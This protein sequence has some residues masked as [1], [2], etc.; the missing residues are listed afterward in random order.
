MRDEVKGSLSCREQ[1]GPTQPAAGESLVGRRGAIN[2]E[3]KPVRGCSQKTTCECWLNPGRNLGRGT[4]VDSDQRPGYDT[5]GATQKQSW[6]QVAGPLR[7]CRA[8]GGI[9]LWERMGCGCRGG[10]ISSRQ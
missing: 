4:D 3:Q 5:K 10:T 7:V 1:Q 2:A 8:L 6:S 9:V